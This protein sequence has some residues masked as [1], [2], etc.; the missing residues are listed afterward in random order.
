MA[1]P[2]FDVLFAG[3]LQGSADPVNVKKR[4][5]ALFKLDQAGVDR[6]FGGQRVFIKRGVDR[7]TAERF[8]DVFAQ[9][10]AKAELERVGGDPEEVFAFDD[11]DD[12]ASDGASDGAG[13]EAGTAAAGIGGTLSLAPPGAPLDELSD[14]GPERNPDISKL[15]LV[16]GDGWS[17]E[18]CAPPPLAQP[19][20]DL[21][22]LALEPLPEDAARA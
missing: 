2:T 15:S 8:R 20:P 10:G 22:E 5:A 12:E 21:D 18:D 6:L 16:E 11:S 7:A 4:L 19:I 1:E 9:A 14:R 3:E 13:G 17:L